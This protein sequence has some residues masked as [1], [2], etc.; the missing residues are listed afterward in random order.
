[1]RYAA[2][3]CA[4]LLAFPAAGLAQAEDVK[5]EITAGGQAWQAAWNAGDAA[6]I[7]ALYAEDAVVMPPGSDAVRGRAAIEAFWQADIDASK[8]MT[9][10]IET[11]EVHA[12]GN[13]AVEVGSYM[14]TGADGSH[15]DH[16]KFIAIW[17]KTDSGW[18]IVRDIFN[19][20]M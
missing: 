5:A 2:L 11:K 9:S 3:F 12:H 20:S 10:T 19:S 4:A 15:A 16:G 7:A 18:K 8:G 13:M 14:S 6:A 1:M 17:M